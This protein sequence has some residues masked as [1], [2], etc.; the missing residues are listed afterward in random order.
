MPDCIWFD[1]LSA[2]DDLLLILKT[3]LFPSQSHIHTS[4]IIKQPL[5]LHKKFVVKQNQKIKSDSMLAAATKCGAK[6]P[7]SSRVNITCCHN[8]MVLTGRNKLILGCK[9]RA[10]N[11]LSEWLRTWLKTQSLLYSVY[12]YFHSLIIREFYHDTQGLYT[13]LTTYFLDSWIFFG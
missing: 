9:T 3:S 2:V 12:Q 8:D 7:C 5:N 13:K 1:F 11:Q 4:K 6:I 10:W